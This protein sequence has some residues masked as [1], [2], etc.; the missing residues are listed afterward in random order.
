MGAVD[1]IWLSMDTPENLMVIEGIMTL[2][3]PVDWERLTDV[4]QHRLV[5]R[6]PVFRQVVVEASSAMG[7]P[8]WEDDPDFSIAHHLHHATLA[9]PGDE[10]ALQAFVERKM[11]EPIDRSRPLWH[12]YLIDG[13]EGGSVVVSRF[14]HALADGIALAE[15]LLSLTDDEPDDDLVPVP[16]HVPGRELEAPPTGLL[17]VAGRFARPLTV[18]VSAAVRG[19][20]QALDEVPAMLHPSYAVEMLSTAWQTGR[21]ADKLLLS[22][23]PDSPLTTAP[24]VAKRA[25]WSEARPLV[26]IKLVGRVAGA[27]VNDVLVGAV[28]AAISHYL[29]DR[30]HDPGDMSTMVPVNVRGGQPLP[31]EL[32]NKFAL[33][34]L[35]LPTSRLAPLERLAESKRRMDSIK[36]SPE[37]LL[38]F[39]LINAIGRTNTT[40][41]K[42]FVDFFAAKAIGVTTN[43]A[44]PRTGRYLAG[45]RLSGILGWVPG[46]GPQT[47]GVCIIS[48]D[49]VVRVGFK[50]D[51]AAVTDPEKLVHAFDSEMDTLVRLSAAV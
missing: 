19:V 9:E 28:S 14:H 22:H 39:G 49:G 26:D 15:V 47:L 45:T 10:A 16:P 42:Q 44:G 11:Q 29:A 17:E 30:G 4:L 50:A 51:A 38:T 20:R 46:S 32:G 6:Y 25:V 7:M 41:A 27:T 33:V 8:H 12:F 3:G 48:Y 43:V 31:R 35:P 37:A 34:M 40:I 36:H 2:E 1:A 18:P 13:Y 5:D 24:G 23:I 21:I